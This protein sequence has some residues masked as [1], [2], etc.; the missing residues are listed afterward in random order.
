MNPYDSGNTDQVKDMLQRIE[1][2]LRGTRK[3]NLSLK[4]RL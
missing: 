4:D 1:D 2:E 3:E